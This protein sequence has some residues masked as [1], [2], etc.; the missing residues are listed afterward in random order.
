MRVSTYRNK[1]L[2][3]L[4]TLGL[5]KCVMTAKACAASA[6]VLAQ[7]STLERHDRHGT[8]VTRYNPG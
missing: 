7:F 8:D 3:Y 2:V 6:F 4:I 1:V 5:A